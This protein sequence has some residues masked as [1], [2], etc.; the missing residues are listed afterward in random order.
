MTTATPP[1][2]PYPFRVLLGRIA[3]E[4]TT[5]RRV[6]DLPAGR[7]WRNPGA[8]DLS[9][10]FLGRRVATPIGPAAGP[11][12]QMAQNIVLAWLGGARM[13]ELK[14]VQV[15]D[16]LEIARPC[17]DVETVGYNVEWSQELSVP[18]SLEEYVKAWMAIEL[19]KRWEP[20]TELVGPAPGPHLF[21]LSVGYD[22]AGISTEKVAG[23]IDAMVD[24]SEV[25]ERLRPEIPEPFDADTPFPTRIADTATLSTFHG[26]PPNEIDA[27]TRHL[28]DRHGLD[29]VVKLNPTLLGF[30]RVREVLYDDLGYTEIVLDPEA[31]EADLQ[32]D[33]ALELV[34]DLRHHARTTGRRFG[35]K[36]TNTLVVRNHRG[37]LP[38]DPMYLSGPPLHVL[39]TALLDRLATALPGVLM[40]P[41]HDGDVQVSFSAGVTKA[42]V[43]ATLAM[44]VG[45]ATICTDLLKPG[46]YGRLSPMLKELAGH[47]ADHGSLEAWRDRRLAE[48]VAAGHRD[49]VAAHL[50]AV[51]DDDRSLYDREG[52]A[53]PPRRVDH[54]L[55]MWGCVAC[56]LCV[57]VCPNDAV[58]RLRTPGG[59][60]ADDGRWQY[61]VL[62]ELCN[63][64]GNCMTFCPETGDPAEVKPRIFLDAEVF[65]LRDGQRFRVVR[66]DGDLA[67]VPAT[68]WEA[69]AGRV[70][71][72]VAGEQGLPLRPTDL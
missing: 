62:T 48:A 6:L 42:N 66:D 33:Q 63:E 2:T 12:T 18:R 26:C 50:A 53:K 55:R 44:G 16:D 32:F 43:A 71:M 72:I 21:D 54:A 9:F 70:T 5:R 39:A 1:L 23:F 61:L 60:D 36:L 3:R 15:L 56:N 30:D 40:L 4:W 19:L 8:P 69:E 14:T 49:T 46:G 45:P 58:V 11:H 31:F 41:G 10:E 67:A 38:D 20:L 57:A 24:A 7:I 51:L 52:T 65:R 29:V 22:L 34:E 17:I 13:F 28:M 37:V 47:V 68:G 25:V 27:I 59:F 35:I 64:C